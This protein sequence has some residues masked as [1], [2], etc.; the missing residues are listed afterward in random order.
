MSNLKKLLKAD[1]LKRAIELD[2]LLEL[3]TLKSLALMKELENVNNDL[4]KSR[5]DIE[6]R[7]TFIQKIL[8]KLNNNGKKV[9]WWNAVY[10][11]K[12]VIALIKDLNTKLKNPIDEL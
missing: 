3:E 10:I 12:M 9:R 6:E 11:I 1:L 7:E 2:S 4:D 5:L 8:E